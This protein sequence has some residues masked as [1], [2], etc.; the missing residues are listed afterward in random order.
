MGIC[1]SGLLDL[2]AVLLEMGMVDET[3]RLLSAEELQTPAAKANAH[4]LKTIDEK[5]CFVLADANQTTGS[6]DVYLTQKDI[7]EVQLAKGAM[8]AG[9]AIM[10]QTLEIDIEQIS[11]VFMA[12]AFGNSM[13]AHS[14]CA[15]GL[16]PKQLEG[17][18]KSIGNAPVRGRKSHS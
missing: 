5:P 10:A 11:Q 2:V 18:I 14:A 1:G 12:G 15:I 13:S 17:K 3:G 6:P 8:A 9:I 4:R 16:I 7:R